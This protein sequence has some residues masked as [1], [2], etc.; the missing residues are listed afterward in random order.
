MSDQNKALVRRWFEELDRQQGPAE[1]LCTPSYTGHH[2]GTPPMN[3]AAHRQFS[4]A[5][6]AAFPDLTHT[7]EDMVA[8]G[9]KVAG[10]VS[11]R[12]THQGELMGIAPTGKQIDVSAIVLVRIE[13]GKVAEFWGVFDQMGIMQQIGAIP[14]PAQAS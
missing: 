5:F 14:V 8:E 7:V 4:S 13:G 9:D 1:D 11:N 10:R 2:P 12:G 3:L 6:F